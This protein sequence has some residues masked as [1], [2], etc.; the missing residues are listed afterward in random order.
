MSQQPTTQQKQNQKGC[1][2]CAGLMLAGFIVFLVIVATNRPSPEQQAK[3]DS[4]IAGYNAA[5]ACQDYVRERLK[6]PASA[7]FQA[8]REAQI[9]DTGRGIFKVESYVDAQNGF[10]A[11]LRKRY[12][13]TATTIDDKTFKAYAELD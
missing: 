8:P 5:F 6:A 4:K 1:L 7:K 12:T 11:M 2:G 9:E 3:E 10:G 13:C